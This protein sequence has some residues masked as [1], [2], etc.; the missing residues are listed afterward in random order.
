VV[1]GDVTVI[2]L[3][4]LVATVPDVIV[5]VLYIVGT[6][7]RTYDVVVAANNNGEVTD[8]T[9]LVNAVPPLIVVNDVESDEGTTTSMKVVVVAPR[10]TRPPT[11]VVTVVVRARLPLVIVEVPKV[12]QNVSAAFKQVVRLLVMTVLETPPAKQAAAP[13][14]AK[15]PK[16]CWQ[17]APTFPLATEQADGR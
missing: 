2:V 4:A 17:T 15:R 13:V 16:A 5:R 10:P 7:M 1:L 9:V 14:F 11:V 8:V 3:G 12:G 6:P